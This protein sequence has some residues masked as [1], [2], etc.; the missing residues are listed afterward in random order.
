M[1]TL[2]AFK[3][4]PEVFPLIASHLPLYA[5]PSTLLSLA[6]TNHAIYEIV[7]NLLY[8]R[9]ILKNENDAISVF[10]KIL[11]NPDLGKA[12]RELHV[13]S[14]LTAAAVN[15]EKAFDTVTG[16]KKLIK[17]GALPYLHT[18]TLRL[19][20][21]SNHDDEDWR[22]A[23]GFGHLSADFWDD[24]QSKCPRVRTIVLSGI[25]DR[26]G[27]PW[28]NESGIYDLKGI[29]VCYF[30]LQENYWDTDDKT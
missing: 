2:T 12:V 6:S 3:F 5:T 7:Q 15:G 10:Q 8:S 19:V 18:F 11:S 9:L 16:L 1:S 4:P 26:R 25:G 21:G 22:D 24:L 29:K 20:Y 13:M 30:S 28:L 23:T 27:D 14:E 17:A